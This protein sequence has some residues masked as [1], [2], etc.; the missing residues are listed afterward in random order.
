MLHFVGTHWDQNLKLEGYFY[1][2]STA[3]CP[4]LFETKM[5]ILDNK[6]P[7]WTQ[8]II[9]R[10]WLNFNPIKT[11][12]RQIGSFPQGSGVKIKM[13]ELAPP[14]WYILIVKQLPWFLF[15]TAFGWILFWT[16]KHIISRHPFPKFPRMSSI[17]GSFG[18]D[19]LAD[20]LAPSWWVWAFYWVNPSFLGGENW[21]GKNVQNSRTTEKLV[22]I[23]VFFWWL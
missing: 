16:K 21:D 22:E 23:S 18:S 8:K 10:W 4:V 6:Q 1:R 12:A 5:V 11:S 15:T 14:R 7:F 3:K 17:P 20:P 13:F 19:P 9:T 2:N